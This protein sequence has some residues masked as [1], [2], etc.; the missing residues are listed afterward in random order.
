MNR[1]D[2]PLW[3]L[4]FPSYK[5]LILGVDPD[6]NSRHHDF[7][8]P[9]TFFSVS[10]CDLFMLPSRNCSSSVSFWALGE[11]TLSF[12][13]PSPQRYPMYLHLLLGLIIATLCSRSLTTNCLL[14][15]TNS[16]CPLGPQWC[17]NPPCGRGPL[18]FYPAPSHPLYKLQ[19]FFTSSQTF[20]STLS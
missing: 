11:M 7:Y 2:S 17:G 14:C 5:I 3:F 19:K 16:Q 10:S 13:P 18:L 15:T 4:I 6:T 1:D 20:T 12:P 8:N 9:D